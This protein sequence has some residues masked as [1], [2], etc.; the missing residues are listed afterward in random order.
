MKKIGITEACDPTINFKW[1][2]W[3]RNGKPAILITKMPR[4]LLPMLQKSDNI[5]VHC[6]ITTFGCSIVEPNVDFTKDSLVAYHQ[7]CKLLTPERVVLRI[8]PIIYWY[9]DSRKIYYKQLIDEAEG[10]IRISFLD[11]YSHVLN[12]FHQHHI[13]LI[14][15]TFHLPLDIR[16]EIWEYLGQPE[17]CCEPNMPS[18]PC[19]SEKD[20]DILDV[21]PNP[22]LKSQRPLCG[23]LGNKVELCTRPPKCTYGC[24]YCYWK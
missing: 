22:K 21:D 19:V 20:C 18:V 2:D 8:D 15:E 4:L 17:I 13:K 6:T 16:Q 12:R 11:L 24:L 3:V 5:I 23:C 14:C 7:L 10:R 9:W 1:I